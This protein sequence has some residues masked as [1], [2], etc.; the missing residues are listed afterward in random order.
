MVVLVSRHVSIRDEGLN[1][2]VTHTILVTV[3]LVVG[4]VLAS[5]LKTYRAQML[6]INLLSIPFILVAWLSA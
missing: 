1:F 4:G 2:M 3:L 5:G 6:T